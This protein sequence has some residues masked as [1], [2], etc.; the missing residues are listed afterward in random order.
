MRKLCTFA[1][2]F[3]AAVFFAVYLLPESALPP[4][5]FLCA[6]A[7]AASLP[8]LRGN[9]RLR[10]A[11]IAF[12]LSA[13]L[14]WTASYSIRFLTPADR[15]DGQTLAVSATVADYPR[16]ASYG[17][18]VLVRLETDGPELKTI[19]YADERYAGPVSYTL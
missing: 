13:G 8:L 16:T 14:L 2:A 3:S 10:A 4:A 6:L 5:G 9:L 15:L 17:V 7:G 12:G 18:S 11:L 19:L 1:L